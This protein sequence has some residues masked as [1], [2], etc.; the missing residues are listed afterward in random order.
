VTA[1]QPDLAEAVVRMGLA[2]DASQVRFTPLE[3]GVSSDI[4]VVDV[5]SRR[6]CVKRALARLRVRS[7]WRAPVERNRFEV[8]YIRVAS[9]IVPAAF[10]ALLGDDEAS[11]CFALEYLPPESFPIWKA[12]LAQGLI[13]D[14]TA[15]RVGDVLGRLH[16][17][18]A[19]NAEI[20][21]RFATDAMFADLRLDPYLEAAAL[22]NPDLADPLRALIAST[23]ACR[24][25]LVHGDYS[26]KNILV[27]PQCPV[28][29]DAECAWYGEPAFDLAFVLN[30]L[31]LKGAWHPPWRPR[32]LGCFGALTRAYLDRVAWEPA[33]ELEARAARLLPGLLLARIDGKSPVEYLGDEST[34]A[35][36]RAFAARFL[37]APA[38]RL[39]EISTAWQQHS[40]RFRSALD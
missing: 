36:V 31:L 20:A 22:A 21:A 10:P 27:G 26:P 33:E 1:G 4:F 35:A 19:D 2:T 7:D 8:A 38:E 15:A 9:R 11:G 37:R 18:T 28:I 16:A 23:R 5:G 34:R 6:F 13:D 3:G 40:A 25:V 39:Y 32:Y 17:A 12:Q 14:E 29:L 30:H 24:R